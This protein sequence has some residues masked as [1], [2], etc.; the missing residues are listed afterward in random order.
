MTT[1]EACW[2]VR[3]ALCEL[4]AECLR[5]WGLLSLAERWARAVEAER[6]DL[7]EY[8]KRLRGDQ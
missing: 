7:A 4:V 1:I 5:A 3:V 2:R 8:S 6:R